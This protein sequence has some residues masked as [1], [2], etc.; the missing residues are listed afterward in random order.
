MSDSW[1]AVVAGDITDRWRPL[2][3]DEEDTVLALIQDAS[4][5]LEDAAERAGVTRPAS[6]TAR[7]ERTY[8][9]IV[10]GMVRRVL[11]NP[12]GYLSERIDDYEYRRSDP[13]TAGELYVATEDIDAL[14]P[15][16]TGR[17]RGGAFTISPR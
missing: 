7:W 1:V 16:T 10:V 15:I 3:S 12:D 2:T 9:R 4:D 14:R 5:M 13:A 11:R 8:T 17:P 6:P